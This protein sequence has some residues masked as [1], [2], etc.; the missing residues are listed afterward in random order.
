MNITYR[1]LQRMTVGKLI[2]KLPCTVSV[3]GKIKF[4]IT[5]TLEEVI[6]P[7]K[8]IKERVV[9]SKKEPEYTWCSH[10][11]RNDLCFDY[12]CRRT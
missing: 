3:D 7:K 2:E 12:T 10:G 4:K 11:N 9:L 8:T 6:T 5:S 1:E